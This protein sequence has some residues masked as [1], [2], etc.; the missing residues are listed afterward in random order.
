M[1]LLRN[2]K[3]SMLRL[4]AEFSSGCKRYHGPAS[5]PQHSAKAAT[6]SVKVIPNC[7]ARTPHRALP[8]ARPPCRTRTYMEIM[9][10]RTHGAAVIWAT[11]FNVARVLI[12]ASPAAAAHKEERARV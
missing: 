6:V 8:S 2:E 12:Q 7:E 9:R 1:S 3:S 11:R 4:Y 5:N 10:A